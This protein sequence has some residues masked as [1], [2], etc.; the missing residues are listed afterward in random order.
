MIDYGI[1]NTQDRSG[2]KLK[3]SCSVAID[4]PKNIADLNLLTRP[5]PNIDLHNNGTLLRIKTINLVQITK[6]NLKNINSLEENG[7]K[8]PKTL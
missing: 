8:Q 2:E 3:R 7:Q 4:D 1:M 6:I 5:E